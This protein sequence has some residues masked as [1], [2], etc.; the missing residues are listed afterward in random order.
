MQRNLPVEMQRNN[1]ALA[2]FIDKER[3]MKNQDKGD[4]YREFEA[5]QGTWANDRPLSGEA[6]TGPE[7][8][9]A[10]DRE[11]PLGG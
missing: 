1:K 2:D 5:L 4:Q 10:R 6:F 9:G 7:Q 8:I 11:W 3:T